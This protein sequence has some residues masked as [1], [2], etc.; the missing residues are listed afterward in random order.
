MRW[1]LPNEWK[2][3]KNKWN[4]SNNLF[5]RSL[6]A[7]QRK[8]YLTMHK[9]MAFISYFM[10][11]PNSVT[12]LWEDFYIILKCVYVFPRQTLEHNGFESPT[13]STNFYEYFFCSQIFP[14]LFCSFHLY[15][16][17]LFLFLLCWKK[18]RHYLRVCFFSPF[19]QSQ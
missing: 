14:S 3:K 9:T 1:M 8:M 6:N 4:F 2:Q 7:L 10:W 11:H 5:C 16:L 13:D 18:H 15:A 19:I 17:P 12:R